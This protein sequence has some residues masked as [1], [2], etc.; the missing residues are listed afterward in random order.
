MAQFFDRVMIASDM[1][2]KVSSVLPHVALID[3]LFTNVLKW[4]VKGIYCFI[5]RIL[6]FS[7]IGIFNAVVLDE[8]VALTR[9]K[10]Q[11]LHIVVLMIVT[12]LKVS[13]GFLCLS[14]YE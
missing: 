11:L 7:N 13:N 6:A 3:T 1:L 2:S 4:G 8:H 14:P 5:T 10:F 12:I 9:V